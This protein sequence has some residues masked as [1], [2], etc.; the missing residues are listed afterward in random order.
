MGGVMSVK[1]WR[2]LLGTSLG[3]ISLTACGNWQSFFLPPED[4]RGLAPCPRV[5]GTYVPSSASSPQ[6]SLGPALV[7]DGE[8]LRVRKEGDGVSIHL[9]GEVTV[10]NLNPK[11]PIR[12]LAEPPDPLYPSQKPFFELPRYP[13]AGEPW[14]VTLS[15]RPV[16]AVVDGGFNPK[17]PELRGQVDLA[18]SGFPEDPSPFPPTEDGS[19]AEVS[20]GNLVAGLVGA[21]TGNDQG[22][23]SFSAGK[24]SLLLYRVFY[25]NPATGES[26]GS[27]EAI[28]N[29]ILDAVD[30]GANVINLSLGSPVD[31]GLR[32]L[33]QYALAKG[34]LVVAAA[35]NDGGE[36]WYPARYPEAVA[37]GATDLLG[38]L[39]PYSSRPGVPHPT[40]LAAPVG[41]GIP[42]VAFGAKGYPEYATM[43]G[44][45]F[46]A[47]Q[48]SGALALWWAYWYKE[49]GN[50]PSPQQA[51]ACLRGATDSDG[52]L[53]WDRFF[54][55]SCP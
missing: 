45:S 34:V 53:H 5:E 51:H 19:L 38:Q 27:V 55:L 37:V 30:R 11:A 28:A 23:A 50:P 41:E 14:Q 32:P 46:A 13:W 9:P 35:G 10:G 8:K 24:A 29:A 25:R 43:A 48:V 18:K 31:P 52:L 33:L 1:P 40:F 42:S 26:A 12:L 7:W 47:P 54:S 15:C 39:A 44:T 20:H 22:I 16:V 36:I 49:K 17:H 3:L 6:G 2:N 21:R 4:Y